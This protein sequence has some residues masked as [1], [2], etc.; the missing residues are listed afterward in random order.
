MAS[1]TIGPSTG[2]TQDANTLE[3]ER[4]VS[5]SHVE[6]PETLTEEESFKWNLDVVANISALYLIYFSSTWAL[7]V[8]ASSIAYIIYAYPS[9][10]TKA[11]WIS[12]VPSLC[13]CVLQVFLGD[14]SDIFG[15][16]GFLV[17]ASVVGVAGML[18]GGRATSIQE[19]IGGQV[20]VGVGMTFGYLSTP[21]LAEVVP[22]RSRPAVVGGGTLLACV[23]TIVGSLSQGAFMKYGVGGVDQGW[24]IGFYLGACFFFL[25]FMGLVFFYRPGPR[26]NPEGYSVMQRLAKFDWFGILLGTAGLLLLLLGLQFGGSPDPWN[27]PQVLCLLIIGIVI[28]VVFG[29]WEWKGVEEGLFPKSLFQHRNYPVALG[30]NL[31]EGMV[32]FSSQTY[33]SQIVLGLLTTDFVMTGVYNL[34][35]SLGTLFGVAFAVV[36]SQRTKEAK[37]VAVTGV[38]S[39]AVGGGLMAVMN[40]GISFAAWFFPNVLIGIGL[41]TLGT[42]TPVIM[43]LCTPNKYIATSVAIGTSVRGL[44]GAVGVVIF[45][46]I[47]SSKLAGFLPARI[48]AV[49]LAAGLPASYIPSFVEAA[50]ENAISHLSQ[51]PGVTD[52]VLKE[53]TQ[54][55]AQAYADS[56]RFIWYGLLP[57]S[58]ATLAVS[59]LLKSTK[60][61]MTLQVAS[62]VRRYFA[63]EDE[64]DVEEKKNV[65][66]I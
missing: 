2:N 37:W 44:G 4:S 59:L 48:G 22:K 12:A 11:A 23:G 21:L 13:L 60:E 25:S 49:V 39:L 24:R 63:R 33:L 36:V 18:V 52:Q 43:T 16:K 54:A 20:L 47:F 9:E 57:F 19:I 6:L 15:R 53:L 27:S 3:K 42:I 10:Y 7:S 50:S 58:F 26:P 35:L 5:T 61:Q 65:S 40:P 28:L 1:T 29:I 32:I 51:I 64:A 45:S 38:A 31:I 17:F 62:Q 41:A 34:P 30:L 46:Q 14:V 66:S 55:K 56:F 8:P